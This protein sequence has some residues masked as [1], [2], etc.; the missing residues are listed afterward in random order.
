MSLEF[1]GK[2]Q[3]IIPGGRNL[4]VLKSD[5]ILSSAHTHFRIQ[6]EQAGAL[7]LVQDRQVSGE[8][9]YIQFLYPVDTFNIHVVSEHY[10]PEFDIGP[11]KNGIFM[12]VP[13]PAIGRAEIILRGNADIVLAAILL[14]AVHDQPV[15]PD[16]VG[17]SDCKGPRRVGMP[18]RTAEEFPSPFAINQKTKAE[19]LITKRVV[20][21]AHPIRRDRAEIL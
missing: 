4:E 17:G 7:I 20:D 3:S 14:Y 13:H 10:F 11:V 1:Y 9:R 19:S 6:A 12:I 8:Y 18:C 2:F 15:L 21:T 5:T 16:M